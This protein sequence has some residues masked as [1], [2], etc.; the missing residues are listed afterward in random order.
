MHRRHFHSYYCN[1]TMCFSGN[2]LLRDSFT[3]FCWLSICGIGGPIAFL[4]VFLCNLFLSWLTVPD[5]GHKK[6][7]ML[8]TPENWGSGGSSLNVGK[9]QTS[10]FA[11]LLTAVATYTSSSG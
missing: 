2:V 1:K 10:W 7:S 11:A 4:F 5:S 8:L 6:L 3:T 9:Y